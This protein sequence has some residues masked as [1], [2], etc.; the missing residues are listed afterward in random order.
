M[1]RQ[2]FGNENAPRLPCGIAPHEEDASPGWWKFPA[3][4]EQPLRRLL[5]RLLQ[6]RQQRRMQIRREAGSSAQGETDLAPQG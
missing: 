6:R 5:R 1:I 2:L 4:T 3:R